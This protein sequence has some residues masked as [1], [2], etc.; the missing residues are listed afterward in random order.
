[1]TCHSPPS[2]CDSG[3][4][5]LLA[6]TMILTPEPEPKSVSNQSIRP[7]PYA[8]KKVRF[9]KSCAAAAPYITTLTFDVGDG[10]KP[11]WL[12]SNHRANPMHKAS[13][14]KLRK[15]E[16]HQAEKFHFL[17]SLNTHPLQQ[18]AVTR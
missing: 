5:L 6:A 1:M 3:I 15:A 11:S 4:Q 9:A 17:W 18:K 10:D 7:V 12:R 8:P 2:T 13:Y 14:D 16:K